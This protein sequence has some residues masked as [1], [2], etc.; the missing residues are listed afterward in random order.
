[1]FGKF[2]KTV[3]SVVSSVVRK[4]LK[5]VAKVFTSVETLAVKVMSAAVTGYER[6]LV[7]CNARTNKTFVWRSVELLVLAMYTILILT[8]GYIQMYTGLAAIFAVA[9]C[10]VLGFF[11][12]YL[13]LLICHKASKMLWVDEAGCNR[14]G[15]DLIATEIAN[16]IK[17]V[18][19][20][21]SQA[22]SVELVTSEW[23]LMRDDDAMALSPA[24]V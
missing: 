10:N 20:W 23:V 12:N 3:K 15:P 6:A 8:M 9:D 4:V 16:V 24:S 19:A 17:S 2:F 7:K 13:G 14:L 1:M 11:V 5:S 22:D 21:Y 18:Y